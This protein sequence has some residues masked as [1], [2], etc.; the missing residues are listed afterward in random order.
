MKRFYLAL[1]AAVI[2]LG[3]TVQNAEAKRLG[4]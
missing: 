1:F 3:L 2:G 4:G